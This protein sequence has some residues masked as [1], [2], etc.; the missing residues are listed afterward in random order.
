[1][2]RLRIVYLLICNADFDI[3]LI[4]QTNLHVKHGQKVA[5]IHNSACISSYKN[6]GEVT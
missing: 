1:M 3:L 5:G 4:I 6:S 2:L